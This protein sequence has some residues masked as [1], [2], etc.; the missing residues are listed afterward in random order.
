MVAVYDVHG[1]ERTLVKFLTR[2]Y[3]TRTV[4]IYSKFNSLYVL[5]ESHDQILWRAKGLFVSYTAIAPGK[6]E[7]LV[8]NF[9]VFDFSCTFIAT[10]CLVGEA[11]TIEEMRSRVLCLGVGRNSS[12]VTVVQR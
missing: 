3:T 11:I 10:Y 2:S 8:H 5:F 12:C 6:T 4:T 7:Q 1:S 9:S